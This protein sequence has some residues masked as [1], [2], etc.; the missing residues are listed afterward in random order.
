[1]RINDYLCRKPNGNPWPEP[2]LDEKIVVTAT[3]S[4]HSALDSLN[5]R[6]NEKI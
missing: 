2:E 4:F 3:E 1:M 5:S 6:L